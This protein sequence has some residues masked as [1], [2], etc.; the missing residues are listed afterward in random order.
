MHGCNAHTRVARFEWDVEK[1]FKFFYCRFSPIVIDREMIYTFHYARAH[2]HTHTHTHTHNP[3][4]TLSQR[5]EK[6]DAQHRTRM[7][8]PK[9]ISIVSLTE[10]AHWCPSTSL[11]VCWE[12]VV[13]PRVCFHWLT[14]ES[15]S[16]FA[17]PHSLL[18][19]CI[20][21]NTNMNA[22]IFSPTPPPTST[23][24]TNSQPPN[25]FA[26]LPLT[27]K[28]VGPD[29][30]LCKGAGAH[31]FYMCKCAHVFGGEIESDTT[32][33]GTPWVWFKNDFII[34]DWHIVNSN[35]NLKNKI[36]P[37]QLTLTKV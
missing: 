22:D 4:Y 36:Y 12:L 35:W 9:S 5:K 33:L 16:A 19:N 10:D 11:M 14:L 13:S 17:S 30:R 1:L 37:P 15:H 32:G 8:D 21:P 29:A 26:L 7:R 18:K 25:C 34:S 20:T 27:A 31:L 24:E 23:P 6:K 28:G 3:T 2:T